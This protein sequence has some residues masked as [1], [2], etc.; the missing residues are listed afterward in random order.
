MGSVQPNLIRLWCEKKMHKLTIGTRKLKIL[1][2]K[3]KSLKLLSLIH[4]GHNDALRSM[5]LQALRVLIQR[6]S[7]C[8]LFGCLIACVLM[9]LSIYTWGFDS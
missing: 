1:L 8:F 6:E 4:M 5:K 9:C 3:Y 2:L 7:Q